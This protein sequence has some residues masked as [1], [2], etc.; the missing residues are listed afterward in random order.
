MTVVHLGNQ[1]YQG[2]TADTKPT[3]VVAGAIYTDTQLDIIYEYNGSSWDIIIGNT[4][5]ETFSGKT[6]DTVL[7]ILKNLAGASFV[8]FKDTDNIFKHINTKTGVVYNTGDTNG[9]TTINDAITSASTTY[10]GAIVYLKPTVYVGDVV[11]KNKV[12]LQGEGYGTVIVG[13][14]TGDQLFDT[15]IEDIWFQNT[16]NN[17]TAHFGG[18]KILTVNRC[19]F[20]G[21]N[22]ATSQAVVR[23]DGGTDFGSLN[24][25][26]FCTVSGY[27]HGF[28]VT[29]SATNDTAN[30]TTIENC[31][32]LYAGGVRA[33]GGQAG[34]NVTNTTTPAG[35]NAHFS[36]N[37]FEVYQY[38]IQ[39][40]SGNLEASD[41]W[42]DDVESFYNVLSGAYTEG[43]LNLSGQHAGNSTNLAYI[44]SKTYVAGSTNYQFEYDTTK[45][46]A[47]KGEGVATLSADGTTK[48]F[49]IA[50][51]LVTTPTVMFIENGSID[52]AGARAVTA[53]STNIVITYQVAPP[54][55]SH[56]VYWRASVL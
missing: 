23:I 36:R 26:Q 28:Q 29:E 32:I 22:G 9:A 46:F 25:F 15:R 19:K 47:N 56:T 48:A 4:K 8:V 54:S 40:D 18:C 42:F 50:H 24:K 21:N 53:T 49:N 31:Y 44:N 39:T 6:I 34:I 27:W 43:R 5:T 2:L 12:T 13:K 11:M 45:V 41:N 38:G 16:G 7:N 1:R 55:G 51:G 30:T 17:N 20:S 52:A 37:Y 33:S 10:S 14:L 35:H 3:N